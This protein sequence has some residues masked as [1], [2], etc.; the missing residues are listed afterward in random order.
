M[1]TF[2]GANDNCLPGSRIA[3]PHLHRM[4]GGTGTFADPITFASF[5]GVLGLEPGAIVYVPSLQ[6]YFIFEDG[7]DECEEDWKKHKIGHL[8][9]WIGPQNSEL[10][11]LELGV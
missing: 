9:L 6:K 10:I 7:C 3:Y 11:Y 1:L 5:P 8:D 2:Y 4:A